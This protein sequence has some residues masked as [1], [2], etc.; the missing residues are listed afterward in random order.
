MRRFLGALTLAA[1]LAL[2]G[3]MFAADDVPASAAEPLPCGDVLF[4]G[5]RGSGEPQTESQVKNNSGQVA[6][7][8]IEVDQVRSAFAEEASRLGYSVNSVAVVYPAESV[9]VMKKVSWVR[10]N[11]VFDG[12]YDYFAGLDIGVQG[13]LQ[14][15]EKRAWDCPTERF[16]L[17]GYSQGAMVMHRALA[18]IERLPDPAD[19]SYEYPMSLVGRVRAVVL[20]ADG[21]RVAYSIAELVGTAPV[22]GVGVGEWWRQ[23]VGYPPGV[24]YDGSDIPD[25][26]IGR[27][28]AI[29]QDD[30]LIC[31][32][33]T[34][35]FA[36][37]KTMKVAKT[38]HTSY[39]YY[40]YGSEA[41]IWA[42]RNIRTC[43]YG[44]CGQ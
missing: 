13:V 23:N 44:G 19:T 12:L 15:V 24:S 34:S 5:A 39:R 1:T 33:G 32:F 9:D 10:G 16:V 17:A 6:G 2:S 26:F 18:R 29:C 38:I 8:G 40:P 43:P 37:N 21:D 35:L 14:I 28:R 22:G 42:A 7:Y 25:P 27:V 11:L 36:T 30:D 41:G 31:D 20:I 4:I 3:V